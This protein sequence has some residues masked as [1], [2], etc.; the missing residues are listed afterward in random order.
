MHVI[1]RG[2]ESVARVHIKGCATPRAVDSSSPSPS[3]RYGFD[4]AHAGVELCKAFNASCSF[5]GRGSSF[6]EEKERE[7]E[8][9]RRKR[10]LQFAARYWRKRREEEGL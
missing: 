10:G 6:M 2:R 9:E 4:T 8:R 7:R 5:A 3:W 1:I